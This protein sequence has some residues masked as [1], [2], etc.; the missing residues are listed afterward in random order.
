M[1][2]HPSKAQKRTARVPLTYKETAQMSLQKDVQK[3]VD[4]SS[5]SLVPPFTKKTYEK[6]S[7]EKSKSESVQQDMPLVNLLL[8]LAK[9]TQNMKK[10]I[11]NFLKVL[12]C[13]ILLYF[14]LSLLTVNVSS[15]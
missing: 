8:F 1:F 10:S 7:E 9:R 6:I 12:D 5:L 11:C 2:L 13:Q 14:P 15:Q 3:L 4:P